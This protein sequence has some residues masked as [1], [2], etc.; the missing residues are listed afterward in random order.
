LIN[1]MKCTGC[2]AAAEWHARE[3]ARLTRAGTPPSFVDGQ[4]A[5]I[6]RIHD[7]EIVTTNGKR[8]EV[9]EGIRVRDWRR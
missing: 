9:F 5:A 4:I 1:L 8:Y 3:R 6:A 7:L 2:A